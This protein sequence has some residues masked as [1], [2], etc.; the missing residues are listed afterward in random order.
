MAGRQGFKT[1]IYALIAFATLDEV[2]MK[3]AGVGVIPF[4]MTGR[5]AG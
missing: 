2:Q 1:K 5:I 4:K 3:M